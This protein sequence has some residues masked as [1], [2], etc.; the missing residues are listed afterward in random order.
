[1][2]TSTKLRAQRGVE[3]NGLDLELDQKVLVLVFFSVPKTCCFVCDRNLF[4]W[5]TIKASR[6]AIT[7]V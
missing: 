6:A 1:V 2:N 4:N 7:F 3:E 5:L